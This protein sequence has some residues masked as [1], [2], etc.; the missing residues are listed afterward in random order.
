[1]IRSALVV[2]DPY[3]SSIV[4]GEKTLEL[5]ATPTKKRELVGII[6]K[7]SGFIV[8]LAR[9]SGCSGPLG[10]AELDALRAR[11]LV[12]AD[13]LAKRPAWRWGWE[14]EAAWRLPEP[15]A[16]RHPNGAQSWVTIADPGL[17]LRIARQC[18]AAIREVRRCAG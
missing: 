11:H 5:R 1:M 8:G 17:R 6:R 15:V 14:L 16:Y 18:D 4:S 3:A 9:V 10:D 12:P 2:V 7:G 13:D